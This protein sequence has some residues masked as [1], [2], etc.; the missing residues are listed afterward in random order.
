MKKLSDFFNSLKFAIKH[1]PFKKILLAGGLALLAG[2]ASFVFVF[3]PVKGKRWLSKLY[4]KPLKKTLQKA[5]DHLIENRGKIRVL[6]VKYKDQLYLEFLAK[7]PDESFHHINS[8]LLDG[9]REAY[10]KYSDS[11]ISLLIFD[12]DGDGQLDVLAPAFDKF[13]RPKINLVVYN[14][15]TGKFELKPGASRPEV[16]PAQFRVRN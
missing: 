6:K 13:L 3:Q 15:R 14:K 1:M 12:D 9:S 5:E 16:I 11:M 2:Y 8:V 4:K 10:F 7:Q